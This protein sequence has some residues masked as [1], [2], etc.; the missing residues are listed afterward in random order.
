MWCFIKIKEGFVDDIQDEYKEGYIK[1]RD[2]EKNGKPKLG[3][4]LN[5]YVEFDGNSYTRLHGSD[6]W[7]LDEREIPLNLKKENG[8]YVEKSLQEQY[9]CGYISENEYKYR[10]IEEIKQKLD[11][12]DEKTTRPLRAILSGKGTDSDKKVLEEI[13]LE[14]QQLREELQ[15]ITSNVTDS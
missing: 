5:F 3:D 4:P 9:E 12:L 10:R 15:A 8:S 11:S 2:I 7:N 14:A 6:L 13:E 1:V